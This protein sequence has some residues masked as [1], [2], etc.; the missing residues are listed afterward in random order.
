[1]AAISCRKDHIE[2]SVGD[3]VPTLDQVGH[4]ILRNGFMVECKNDLDC[5]SRCGSAHYSFKPIHPFK[6]LE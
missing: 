5:M 6:P 2:S 1:V 4:P 3:Y